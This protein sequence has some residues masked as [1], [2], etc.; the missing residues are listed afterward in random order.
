MENLAN[1]AIMLADILNAHCALHR[2]VLEERLND[3]DQHFPIPSH[4][5]SLVELEEGGAKD[6]AL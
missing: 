1:V 3:F 4:S 5:H 2:K 6:D